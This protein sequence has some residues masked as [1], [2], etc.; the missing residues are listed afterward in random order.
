MAKHILVIDNEEA[1]R[2]SFSLALEDTEYE[3]DTAESGAK[4]LQ[5]KEEGQYDLI[6]L[7]LKMPGMS[8]LEVMKNRGKDGLGYYLK[9]G[10]CLGHCLHSVVGAVKQPITGKGV[11][12]SNCE[13]YNW[14]EL[15][16]FKAKN[17]SEVLSLLLENEDVENVVKK[18]DGVYAF[19][20]LKDGKV[21]LARDILGVKP[22]WFSYGEG[23]S[24][25]SEKKALEKIGERNPIELNP[26]KILIYDIEKNKI[27]FVEREFFKII[28]EI[29]VSKENVK[30]LLKK[31]VKKRIPDRKFGVLFSGGVDSVVIALILKELK[32]DFTCYVAGVASENMDEAEDIIYAKKAAK[33]LKVP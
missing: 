5:L 11:L 2:K 7:D 12:V 21:I 18:L 28:P 30:K 13:I 6:F 8:G 4:G 10:Y 17:D 16:E 25:A 33:A 14:E 1:V 31:A 22:L 20:Y 15:N 32:V 3:I 27:E 26:R 19:A 9:K 29:K 24:F 23:L